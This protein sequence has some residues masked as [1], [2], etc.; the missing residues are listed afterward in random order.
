MGWVIGGLVMSDTDDS[1]VVASAA[2]S[3]QTRADEC[4]STNKSTPFLE[5]FHKNIPPFLIFLYQVYH[6]TY[7]GVMKNKNSEM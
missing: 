7:N 3:G 5:W 6:K 4:K 1:F 2:A